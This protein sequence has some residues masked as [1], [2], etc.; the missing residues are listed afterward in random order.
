[1][2]IIAYVIYLGFKIVY[3][4]TFVFHH[5]PIIH[6]FSSQSD[7]DRRQV[8]GMKNYCLIEYSFVLRHV[9]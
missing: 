4:G 3:L 8:G 1:M 5:L 2:T 6:S 7:Q 9:C